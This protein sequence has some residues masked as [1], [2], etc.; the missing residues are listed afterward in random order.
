[1]PFWSLSLSPASFSQSSFFAFG[2]RP[3]QARF[4]AGSLQ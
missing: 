2:A 3:E 4:I 1:M